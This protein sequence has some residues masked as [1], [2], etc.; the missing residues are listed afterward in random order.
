METPNQNPGTHIKITETEEE[1]DIESGGDGHGT[2]QGDVSIRN[3][4][5]GTP[6]DD[7]GHGTPQ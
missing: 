1:I 7:P 3:P 5:H 2:P 4:G 6:Q